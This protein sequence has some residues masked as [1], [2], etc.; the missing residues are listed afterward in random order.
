MV[1]VVRSRFSGTT[2][3]ITYRCVQAYGNVQLLDTEISQELCVFFVQ[4][5]RGVSPYQ[6]FCLET[7][8]NMR[9]STGVEE[10]P[11][12]TMKFIGGY[13]ERYNASL[14]ASSFFVDE[15]TER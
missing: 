15:F 7:S 3:G 9:L 14:N 4:E 5:N 13:D 6:N 11:L 8:M 12:S 2:I 10:M 1:P